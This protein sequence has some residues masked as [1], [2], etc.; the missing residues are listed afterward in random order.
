MPAVTVLYFAHLRERL[1]CARETVELPGETDTAALAALL[2]AR[3]A[4]RDPLAAASFARCRL[5]LDHAFV[6]GPV[7]LGPGAELAVIPPV[8]GG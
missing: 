8:S 4:A 3:H 1:G 5:A 2:A 6:Q 7:H